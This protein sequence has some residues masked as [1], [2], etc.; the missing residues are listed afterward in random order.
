MI[1][2]LIGFA[3]ADELDRQ[4]EASLLSHTILHG[5]VLNDGEDLSWLLE[6]SASL[7]NSVYTTRAAQLPYQLEPGR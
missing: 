7:N 4:S 1:V 6:G 3:A 2:M 5:V